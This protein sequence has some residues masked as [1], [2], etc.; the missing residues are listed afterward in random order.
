MA[1]TAYKIKNNYNDH[2]TATIFVAG[3]TNQSK[4]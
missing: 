1:A 4:G 3:F 2:Q